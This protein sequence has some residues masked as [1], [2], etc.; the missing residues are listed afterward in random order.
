MKKIEF[1]QKNFRIKKKYTICHR[2]LV[3]DCVEKYNKTPEK[4]RD[5]LRF[6]RYGTN[7]K[8]LVIQTQKCQKII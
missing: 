1:L 6:R 8:K 2:K 3:V 7:V 5:I 4:L